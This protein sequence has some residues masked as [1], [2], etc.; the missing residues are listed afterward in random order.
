MNYLCRAYNGGCSTW[1]VE[2]F[3]PCVAWHHD[4]FQGTKAQCEQYALDEEYGRTPIAG[5]FEDV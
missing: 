5:G 2:P 3:D 4:E 1:V